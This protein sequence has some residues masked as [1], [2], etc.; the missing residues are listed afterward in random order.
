M[1]SDRG[2]RRR[3]RRLLEG[4]QARLALASVVGMGT[5]V[6]AFG[7]RQPPVPRVQYADPVKQAVASTLVERLAGRGWDLPNLEHPRVDY[8]VDRFSTDAD[9]RAKLEGF[10]SRSGQYAPMIAIKLEEHDM[11]HDLV[12]LAMIESG[13]DA[14]AYSPAHAA[15]LW[16]FVAETGR[17]YGLTVDRELDERHHPEKETDAALAYLRD[18]HERFGSWYLAAAAYNT[19]ENRVG[20]IMRE[21]TGSERAASE[22]DYYRIWD[23]LPSETRDYV[24]LMIAVARI[25][26]EPARYGFDH[27]V[28]LE[29]PSYAEVKAPSHT[30]LAALAEAADVEVKA[31]RALNPWIRGKRTPGTDGY[32][33]R[34]PAE[35]QTRAAIVLG[36]PAGPRATSGGTALLD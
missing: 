10:L 24:P 27:I 12:F 14:E 8:W 17:R 21:V 32:A 36:E 20:R 28:P 3:I 13:F 11:P 7:I 5:G 9:M 31:L 33:V 22:A 30:P 25:A 29:P 15:G 35:T 1:R 18:L 6:G 26:K 23:R 2:K 16:Q 34:V 4:R 19:G